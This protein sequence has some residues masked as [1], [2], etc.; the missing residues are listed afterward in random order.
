MSILMPVGFNKLSALGSMFFIGKMGWHEMSRMGL[1]VFVLLQLWAVQGFGSNEIKIKTFIVRVDVDA[2]PTVFPTHEHWYKSSVASVKGLTT[3]ELQ[4]ETQND[5]LLHVY[6]TVFSGFS[7]RLTDS[8]ASELEKVPGILALFPDQARQIQTTRS[9]QFLGLKPDG[10]GLWAESDYGSDVIIGIMDTGIWPERRSFS[11]LNIGPVPARWKGVCETGPGFES[12]ACNRKL[13]GARFLSKGYEAAMRG[14]F[15]NDT[16]E[17]RSPRDSDGHGTHTASTAAGRYVDQASML[18]FARGVATGVAPKAR[19]AAYKVCWASGCYDSDILAGFDRAV[20]DGVNVISLSVGGGVVPYYLDSIALGAF[21]AMQRGVFVS[22]SAGNEGPGRETVTNV[23]PW[24]ATIGAGTLDRDFPADVLLGNGQIIRGVSLYSGKGL[25]RSRL[26]PL[27]YAGDASRMDDGGDSYSSS[28]CMEGTLD[29]KVVK[30]TVVLCERGNN[31]RVGKGMEVRSAGGIG[32]ILTNKASDGEGLVA[33]A[34]VLPAASVG[35]SAG[36][37]IRRYI[38]STRNATATLLFYGTKLGVKP[39]PV[40]AEFSARG[41]NPETPEILKPDIIAPGV[42]ILAAWTGATSPSGLSSDRRRTE[43]NIISGTSMAC[44]H[45]S[46]LAALLKG[47]HPDWSPAAIKSALMTTAYVHDNRAQTLMDESSGQ[48]ASAV[49]FGAGH[50]DPQRAVDPGLIYDLTMED[51]V[52]FLCGL[53]YSEKSL[54]V[55]THQP[56]VNC[57]SPKVEAWN[58]NYPSFAA[59]FYQSISSS[60][61][62]TVF[63]RTVTNV[64]PALSTYTAK[65]VSPLNG[66]QIS[67]QPSILRFTKAKEKLSYTVTVRAEPVKLDPGTSNTVSALLTWADGTHSV[68]SPIVVIR[69]EPY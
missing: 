52:K 68:Q 38:L 27:V 4:E 24:I 1:F 47:A 58:L 61:L 30:G 9:P 20:V 64:G 63:V 57:P 8:Q 67:V 46:G 34:H 26:I 44:P 21:G 32:M 60:N 59:V 3:E 65:V 7:T 15:L 50:V 51:Y 14:G 2:K 33:D 6:D 28:L 35:A 12:S 17:F 29:P 11:D 19:L 54:K 37:T 5:M 18:G 23:A 13:V 45:V 49:D 41:P 22:A 31:Q 42:N 43:F 56:V 40:L 55:I 53:N 36:N 10:G 62:A 16:V 48:A 25:S 39:A 69:K 66:V